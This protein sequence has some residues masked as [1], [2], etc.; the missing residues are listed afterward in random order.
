MIAG[1]AAAVI[2]LVGLGVWWRY[3]ADDADFKTATAA[4]HA[5]VISKNYAEGLVAMEAYLNGLPPRTHRYNVYLYQGTMYTNM[6]DN[7]KAILAFQQAEKLN[8]SSTKPELAAIAACADISGDSQLAIVYYQ[9][10]IEAFPMKQA[11]AQFTIK[12]YRDRITALKRK[13]GQS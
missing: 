10:A 2:L 11:A 3:L 8:T 4:Q 12:R 9:K 5:A 6:H 7:K 13:L 1:V